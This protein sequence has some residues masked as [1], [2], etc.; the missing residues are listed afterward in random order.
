MR[1]SPIL[2]ARHA[3]PTLQGAQAGRGDHGEGSGD[4]GDRDDHG[5]DGR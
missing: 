4:H 5:D 2:G 3:G 1:A